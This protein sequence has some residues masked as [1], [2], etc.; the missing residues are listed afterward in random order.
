MMMVDWNSIETIAE[1]ILYNNEDNDDE[2]PSMN[3]QQTQKRKNNKNKED[4]IWENVR[5]I[6]TAEEK[7]PC[8][9]HRYFTA[10]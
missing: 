9:A 8:C 5:V 7:I 1:E 4:E 6:P 10:S 3:R 2:D